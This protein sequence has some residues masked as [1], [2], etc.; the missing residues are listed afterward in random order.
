MLT[1]QT[2]HKLDQALSRLELTLLA[3]IHVFLDWRQI[4]LRVNPLI[5]AN[6]SKARKSAPSGQRPQGLLLDPDSV[7]ASMMKVQSLKNDCPSGL[8]IRYLQ[9]A[10]Y[11]KPACVVLGLDFD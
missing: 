2:R 8:Q 7:E 10:T 4:G 6:C 1:E 11:L 3:Q 5:M 9:H